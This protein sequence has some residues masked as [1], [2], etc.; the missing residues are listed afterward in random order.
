MNSVQAAD[1][2]LINE[3]QLGSQ[4]NVAIANGTRVKFN[5]LLSLL[6]GNAQDF[7]QFDLPKAT[8][9]S[10]TTQELRE[11]FALSDPQPLVNTGISLQQSEQL[12]LSI[13]KKNLSDVR[14]QYLLNN[15]AI[16]SRFNKEN[17]DA[18]IVDNLSFLA[19]QR[20][21]K[22]EQKNQGKES[23]S[24]GVDYALVKDYQAL[25]FQ[26][27]PVKVSYM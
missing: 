18:D 21:K 20:L 1:G 6:S 25:N 24:E 15:E 14:L 4:L 13:H 3:W 11:S 8:Q 16:L 12:S 22:A 26:E 9:D 2:L 10:L 23:N 19:Q 27:N 5:L 17:F 7:S